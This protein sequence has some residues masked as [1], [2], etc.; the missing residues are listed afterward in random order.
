MASVNLI[1]SHPHYLS[2]RKLTRVLPNKG[3]SITRTPRYRQRET[4]LLSIPGMF[5]ETPPSTQLH[6]C[7]TSL[8]FPKRL[9]N[10]RDN[11]IVLR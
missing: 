5:P 8:R 3:S 10:C 2:L 4:T 9:R 7:E 1:S 11:P 6:P